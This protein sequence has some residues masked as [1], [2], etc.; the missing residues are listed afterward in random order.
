MNMREFAALVGVNEGVVRR[1]VKRGRVV[2]NEDG[3]IDPVSQAERWH[4]MR[5]ESKVRSQPGRPATASTAAAS[6]SALATVALRDQKLEAEIQLLRQRIAGMAAETV[7]RRNMTRAIAAFSRT[8]RDKFLGLADRHG[9][10]LAAACGG[11][12]KALMSALERTIRE[13]LAEVAKVRPAAP[14]QDAIAHEARP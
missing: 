10:Q 9:L 5:N 8:I 11:E 4:L 14:A 2:L 12:P 13:T 1:A 3:S 7:D 6:R